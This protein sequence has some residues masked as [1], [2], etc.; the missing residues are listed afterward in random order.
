MWPRPCGTGRIYRDADYVAVVYA[1]TLVIL[2][3]ERAAQVPNLSSFQDMDEAMAWIRASRD[4]AQD[5]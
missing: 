5:Q 1:S 3:I 4:A 2:Q